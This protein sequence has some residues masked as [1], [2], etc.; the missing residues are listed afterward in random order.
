MN[1]DLGVLLQLIERLGLPLVL[2]VA[3]IQGWI[4]PK[5]VY[6]QLQESEREFRELAL[7]SVDLTTHAVKTGERL[8]EQ[9]KQ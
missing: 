1:I 8:V 3:F 4:V 9:S 5:Y 6:L 7:R 2:V